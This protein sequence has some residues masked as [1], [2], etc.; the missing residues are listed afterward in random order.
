MK[1]KLNSLFPSVAALSL[2]ASAISSK[3]DTLTGIRHRARKHRPAIA[4][5]DGLGIS[6]LQAGFLRSDVRQRFPPPQPCNR[7]MSPD[8]WVALRTSRE[9]FWDGFL[10]TD[11]H[12]IQ[13]T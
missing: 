4:F 1:V 11:V 9:D 7:T 6:N 3:A 5:R 2:F 8:E 13:P 12:Q 10:G